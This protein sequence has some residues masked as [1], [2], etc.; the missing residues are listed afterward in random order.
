MISPL[1]RIDNAHL[2]GP[3]A[4]T[5][6]ILLYDVIAIRRNRSTITRD[7]HHLKKLG[8]GPEVSGAICG[9]LIFHL[10]FRDR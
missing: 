10:L 1:K 6:F 8:Y 9:L 7:V 2:S 4:L 5:L 3:L